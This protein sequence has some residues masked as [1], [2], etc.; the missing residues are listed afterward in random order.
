AM[1]AQTDG[2]RVIAS[3]STF[4][5]R[6]HQ[7]DVRSI[8]DSLDV[9]HVLEGGLQKSGSRLRVQVRLVDGRDGSTLWSETFDRD[10][11]DVFA[12]QDD[13]A[14]A[15]ARELDVRLAGANGEPLRR[16]HTQNIAAYELY[17]RGT[18]RTLLRSDSA[19]REGLEY[20]RQAI[21]LDSTYAAAWAGLGRMYARVGYALPM[22]DR[23]RYYALAEEAAR[24][25]VALDDSL[26]E[27]HATLGAVRLMSFDFASAERHLTRAIELDPT[28]AITYEW[29]VTLYLWTGRPR[30]ALAAAERALELDPLSPYAHAEVARALLFNDRCDEA[31]AH[32]E[33]LVNLQP[34]LLR[35]APL[36]AQCYARKQMWPEAIAVLRPQA[37]RGGPTA[38]ALLG[39]ML[40]RAGQREEALRIHA[41]LLERWRRGNGGAFPVA[42]VYAGLGD[43]DQAFAWLDRSIADRSLNGSP[44]D[45]THLMLMGPLFEDLRRDPRFARLRERLGLQKQ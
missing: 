1:L 6:D 31:L 38:L 19:A 33:K 37:E 10:M 41:T 24:K 2:L 28:R 20:L 3:T 25:A 7:L 22:P 32:L 16:P 21:A 9:A 18:D 13:I 39:Y 35:V 36:A 44:G 5:F 14:R 23:E 43:L 27:A 40:A 11:Q 12:V 8:A 42:L 34:P 45:P 30:E 26:G 15:V 4:S 29:V 17:L